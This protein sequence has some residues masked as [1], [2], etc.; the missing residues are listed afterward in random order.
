MYNPTDDSAKFNFGNMEKPGVFLDETV[1]RSTFNLRINYGR[2]GGELARRGEKDKA[3]EVL[4][5]A[6]SKMPV[7]KLGYDY[8]MLSMI[9]GYYVAGATEKAHA[10]VEGFAASLEE[11][12]NYF[13]QFRGADKRAITN[14]IQTSLQF[15]QMLVRMV[16]QYEFN[17]APMTQEQYDEVELIKRYE[18]ASQRVS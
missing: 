2:L 14:E 13:A 6:M 12:L 16:M 10:F 15:Y 11:E 9:E 5:Y 1:R 18:E 4:D 7:E 17:N 3:V 8:F